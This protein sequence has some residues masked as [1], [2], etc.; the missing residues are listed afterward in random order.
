MTGKDFLITRCLVE[1]CRKATGLSE[2]DAL[3]EV[4]ERVC[5]DIDIVEWAYLGLRWTEKNDPK[6]YRAF[7]L[8]GNRILE[9]IGAYS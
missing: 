3:R 8:S 9:S 4:N 1:G 5:L 6:A 2:S 7:E